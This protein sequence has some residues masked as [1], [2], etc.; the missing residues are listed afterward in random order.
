MIPKI[1]LGVKNRK[2]KFTNI[3]NPVEDPESN[4]SFFTD[5]QALHWQGSKTNFH[6]QFDFK[7]AYVF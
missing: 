6:F 2:T 4:S 1:G 5:T 7:L 3:I